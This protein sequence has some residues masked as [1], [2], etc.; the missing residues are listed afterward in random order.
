[1]VITKKEKPYPIVHCIRAASPPVLRVPE[2]SAV[3]E[4]EEGLSVIT[5]HLVDFPLDECVRCGE[6]L[7]DVIRIPDSGMTI[8][9]FSVIIMSPGYSFL[10]YGFYCD[11]W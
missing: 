2:V 7:K 11:V 9:G 3:S 8:S 4:A 1:M 5:R 6:V 10:E